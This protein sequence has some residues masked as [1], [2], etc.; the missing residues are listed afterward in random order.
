[1]IPNS[2]FFLD[3]IR[4][5]AYR[6]PNNLSQK[7]DTGIAASSSGQS[8][9]ARPDWPIGFDSRDPID[10]RFRHRSTKHAGQCVCVAWGLLETSRRV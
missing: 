3:R 8:M 1:L 7:A 6:L 4:A 10:E 5:A 2:Y 9:A